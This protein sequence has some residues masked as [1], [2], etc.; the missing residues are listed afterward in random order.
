M[1]KK[2]QDTGDG[3]HRQNLRES[4]ILLELH[5]KLGGGGW[6]WVGEC[7]DELRDLRCGQLCAKCSV[8]GTQ[9]VHS[10]DAIIIMPILQTKTM[11]ITETKALLQAQTGSEGPPMDSHSGPLHLSFTPPPHA[12]PASCCFISKLCLT[13]LGPHGL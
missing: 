10:W 8:E 7:R 6:G 11:R 12:S 3:T 4:R 9:Y 1:I 13:L 2:E 5:T